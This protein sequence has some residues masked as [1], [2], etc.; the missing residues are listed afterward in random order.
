MSVI[1]SVYLINYPRPDY[2]C[3]ALN[4]LVLCAIDRVTFYQ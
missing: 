4:S 2:F 1:I 3:P